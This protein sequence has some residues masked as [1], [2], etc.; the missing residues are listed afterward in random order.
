MPKTLA[1]V[2]LD[3]WI[4]KQEEARKDFTRANP[5]SEKQYMDSQ[6]KE[7]V[8]LGEFTEQEIQ[9]YI[10][11]PV[12]H[13]SL[14]KLQL[15]AYFQTRHSRVISAL[16]ETRKE[17]SFNTHAKREAPIKVALEWMLVHIS[18]LV[19]LESECGFFLDGTWQGEREISTDGQMHFKPDALSLIHRF[20]RQAFGTSQ[21][22]PYKQCFWCG[23]L[24]IQDP[25]NKRNQKYDWCADLCKEAWRKS[26]GKLRTSFNDMK[27]KGIKTTSETAFK[28]WLYEHFSK[29]ASHI[30]EEV[31]TK[32][33]ME[34]NEKT[35]ELMQ[36]IH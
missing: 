24:D 16:S 7:L 30:P 20:W 25:I 11:D 3:F 36:L 27:N 35:L 18:G 26:S 34:T 12:E 14:K 28:S 31:Q 9:T 33:R 21:P 32:D 10:I 5:T 29:V 6:L 4:E 19:F 8:R 15:I 1:N 23:S 2:F 13:F 17:L 22:V